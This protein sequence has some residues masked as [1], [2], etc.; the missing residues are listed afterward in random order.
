MFRQLEFRD[1]IL[2]RSSVSGAMPRP[3]I[4]IP[5]GIKIVSYGGGVN[6]VA[7]LIVLRRL[8]IVPEAITMA[9]PGSEWQ[10]TYDYRDEVVRPW[11][12]KIGFPDIV[13]VTRMDELKYRKGGINFETLRGLCDRTQSLPSVAYPPSKKCSQNY[14]AA[15]QRWWLDRQPWAQQEW[16]EGRRLVRCIGYD[17]DE[18][19]RIRLEFGDP[20]EKRKAVP[21]YPVFESGMDREACILLIQ[22]DPDLTAQATSVGRSPVP[23]KSACKWC[24]NNSLQDWHDLLRVDPVGFLDAVKMSRQA[25]ATIESPDVVGLL[26]GFA[27]HGKR[28]LHVW[29]DGGYGTSIGPIPGQQPLRSCETLEDELEA[30]E[31]MPCDCRI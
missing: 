8:G 6:S 16:Q 17:T 10:E 29:V 18:P 5:E 23:R 1:E 30:Q 22:D 13:V 7:L 15:P 11:L 9:D 25:A 27:P 12:A 31:Q 3:T 26:R 14:K 24:P 19:T 2:E 21:W 4:K 28:H 20:D